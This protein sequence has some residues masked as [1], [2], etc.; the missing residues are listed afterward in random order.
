M[1]L[2][3]DA[4]TIA[5]AGALEQL[6][7][8]DWHPL[9]FYSR[10]LKEPET[11]YSTFD[12][13]LLAVHDSLLNYRTWLGS[14]ECVVYTNHK[15]LTFVLAKGGDRANDR[16]CRQLD[17]ISQYIS[18]IRFIKGTDNVVA[19]ALSRTDEVDVEADVAAAVAAVVGQ[20]EMAPV[21]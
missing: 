9:G 13:E 17:L 6:I 19:D 18:E 1:R 14:N 2:T 4:S 10:K 5:I 7:D 21:T 11:R 12:R 3:T 15:P 20:D 16:Q 8:R